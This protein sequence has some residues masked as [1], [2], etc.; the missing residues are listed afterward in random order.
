[1]I[2]NLRSYFL[3]DLMISLQARAEIEAQLREQAVLR[4]AEQQRLKELEEIRQ[5]MEKL[6]EEERQAK[7]DEEIV[8]N[9]QARYPQG[10]VPLPIRS[11]RREGGEG[12]QS[13]LL[14]RPRRRRRVRREVEE[15]EEMEDELYH[16]EDIGKKGRKKPCDNMVP[17]C[18]CY[19]TLQ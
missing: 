1:M 18:N 7:R 3:S 8:R 16:T 2:L 17:L 13:L 6:L 19:C 4:E 15:M 14:Q 12:G 9:L 11:G 10:A 5:Q